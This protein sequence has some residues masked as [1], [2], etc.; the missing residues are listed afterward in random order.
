VGT[1][2]FELTYTG[3]AAPASTR[4]FAQ[5]VDPASNLVLGNQVTP[6]PVTLDGRPHTIRRPLEPVAFSAAAGSQLKLQVIAGTNVYAP[7]RSSGLVTLSRVV[8]RL[9][10]AR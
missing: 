10:V 7:Q 6:I 3:T 2:S 1:P 8:V 9:P 4:I 5:L